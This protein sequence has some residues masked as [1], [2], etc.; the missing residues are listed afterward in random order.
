[1]QRRKLQSWIWGSYKQLF[2]FTVKPCVYIF[3]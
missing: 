1:M 2:L 3:L